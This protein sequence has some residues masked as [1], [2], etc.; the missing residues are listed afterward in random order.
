MNPFQKKNDYM[1]HHL[2]KKALRLRRFSSYVVAVLNLHE[3]VCGSFKLWGKIY[4]I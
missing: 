1:N 2:K 3:I 4:L